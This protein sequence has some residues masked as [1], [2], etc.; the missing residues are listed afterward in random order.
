[1]PS[2]SAYDQL[3][4]DE[5]DSLML[6]SRRLQQMLTLDG[7]TDREILLQ[8]RLAVDDI[9]AASLLVKEWLASAPS[10]REAVLNKAQSHR[11]AV[12]RRSLSG[13]LV[14][15]QS[16]QI[17]TPAAKPLQELAITVAECV[18]SDSAAFLAKS[19]D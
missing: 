5:L 16:G 2:R 13:L 7:K 1:M 6:R 4:S 19:L 9:R 11:L 3:F 12:A 8:F 10:E 15:L 18:S 17:S 14:D